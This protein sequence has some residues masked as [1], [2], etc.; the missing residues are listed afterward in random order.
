MLVGKPVL[1]I[2]SL[3]ISASIQMEEGSGIVVGGFSLTSIKV[4]YDMVVAISMEVTHDM[5]VTI[6]ME[7]E[8]K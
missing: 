2:S 5:V 1:D 6:S 7:V 4:T 8:V 3:I